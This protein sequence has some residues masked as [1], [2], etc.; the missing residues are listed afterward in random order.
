[1]NF[2]IQHISPK[3][4]MEKIEEID[5]TEEADLTEEILNDRLANDATGKQKQPLGFLKV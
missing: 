3:E 5:S 1:M 2:H 4:E